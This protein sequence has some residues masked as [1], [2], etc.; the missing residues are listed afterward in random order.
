[1]CVCVFV[2]GDGR[3]RERIEV[4]VRVRVRRI[5]VGWA[6]NKHKNPHRAAIP[7]N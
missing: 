7:F 3:D 6:P 5:Y 4:R 2:C 1:M